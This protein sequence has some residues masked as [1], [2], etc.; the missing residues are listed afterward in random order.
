MMSSLF[1]HV[2]IPLVI[3]LIFSKELRLDTRMVLAL[4]FFA[5]LPDVDAVILPHRAVLHNVFVLI[6]PSLLFILV[7]SRREIFGIIFFYL[8]S[9]LILDMFNGGIFLFYP[10]YNNVFF[11][12]AEL[13]FTQNSFIPVLDYGIS[14]HIMNMGK[15]E[16][17]ISSENIGVAALLIIFA[18]ILVLQKKRGRNETVL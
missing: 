6:I 8:A 14:T 15:G 7:K 13:L 1:N 16:P 18:L 9:H 17:V 2:F 12:H 3:L 11:A 4:S 5:L 10:F